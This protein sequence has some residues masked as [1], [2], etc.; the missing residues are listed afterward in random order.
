MSREEK[1]SRVEGVLNKLKHPDYFLEMNY[2]IQKDDN[3][4][5]TIQAFRS[6]HS[7]HKQPTKGGIRYSLDVCADE[8]KALSASSGGLE[9]P[10]E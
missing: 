10:E 3:T 4:Y 2:A 5:E 7:Q 6:Q 9:D 8:V 1:I